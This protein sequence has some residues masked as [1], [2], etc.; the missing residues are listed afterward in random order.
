[1]NMVRVSYSGH[2]NFNNAF[3]MLIMH[4]LINQ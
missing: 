4:T 1:M 3:G 2:V